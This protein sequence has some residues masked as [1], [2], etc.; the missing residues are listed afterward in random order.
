ML[1]SIAFHIFPMGFSLIIAHPLPFVKDPHLESIEKKTRD[2]L[3]DSS[4]FNIC[5]L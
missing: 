1:A 4:S 2:P 3:T 5:I